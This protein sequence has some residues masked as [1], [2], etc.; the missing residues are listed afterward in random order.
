MRIQTRWKAFDE[1]PFSNQGTIDSWLTSDIFKLKQ[2]RS[3]RAEYSVERV[4]V[5][6]EEEQPNKE[7]I[8]NAHRS[9]QQILPE[10]DELWARWLFFARFHG[11]QL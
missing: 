8:L 10:D 11:V 9:L 2:P 1:V 6:M 3:K 5:L 7:E 4:R